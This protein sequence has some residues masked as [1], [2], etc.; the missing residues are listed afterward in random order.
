MF[1]LIGIDDT[2]NENAPCTGQLGW[3][4][5]LVLE[6]LG[7]CRLLSVTRHMLLQDHSITGNRENAAAC[8][9]IESDLEH[10]RDLELACRQYLLR[11][12]AKGAEP[13]YALAPWSQLTPAISTWGKLAKQEAL[14]RV[15]AMHLAR[16]TGISAA[17][18]AGTGRGVIGALAAI[19]L[20]HTGSD[21]R[22]YW[23]PGLRD[24]NG[25]YTVDEL[26]TA[27]PFDR[28]ENRYGRR[29]IP[30]DRIFIDGWARP[31]LRDGKALLLLEAS[32]KGSPY[33]WETLNRDEVESLAQ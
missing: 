9:L 29:P 33:E 16:S 17:G 7:Y 5:G 24:L 14:K 18:L 25:I 1:Y 22:Y 6:T 31:I 19:G 32:E 3:E 4:L 27:C 13:G 21:G 28:L 8:L 2:D 23:L 11:N 20:F 30:R 12:S 10:R 15:D 26:M